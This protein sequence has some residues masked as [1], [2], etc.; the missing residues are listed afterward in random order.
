M[1]RVTALLVGAG[2]RGADAYAQYALAHPDEFKIVGVCEPD[3]IR[4][5]KVKKL[6]GLAE[7]AC[8]KS[9]EDVMTLPQLADT[10][11]ICT[12]DQMHY[13]PAINLMEKG[14]NL[15]LEKPMS[16]NILESLKI[17]KKANELGRKVVVCHVLRYTQFF[18]YIKELLEKDAIGDIITIQHNENVAFWHYA[19]SYVRGAWR[20]KD[21]SSPMILAK[22]CHDMDIL[23]WL[24]G[25]KCKKIVSFGDLKYFKEENAPVGAPKKCQDGCPQYMDCPWYAPKF[26][27]QNQRFLN[28]YTGADESADIEQK[29][30]ALKQSNHGNCVFHSD[31][32]VVDHQV[33]LLEYQNGVTVTFTMSAFTHDCSRTIR[34][35]G[36]KGNIIGDMGKNTIEVYNYLSDRKESYS[37]NSPEGDIHF[38]GDEGIMQDF[39]RVMQP[40]FAGDSKSSAN[41]SLE[42]H[43]MAAAAEDSRLQNRIIDLEKY[44]EELAQNE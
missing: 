15:L 34:I 9:W 40:D 5:E 19:M 43:V 23:N 35:M 3:I 31:N 25:E 42:S 41:I 37:F 27:L 24:V 29:L 16:S 6:H 14:Y 21:I 10:A 36:T 44:I 22:C 12:Q 18:R 1:N 32:D 4:K 13:Q 39:V 11:L 28:Q 30:A 2:G 8:Y 20:R 17:T 33:A 7:E 26:Y 38:G